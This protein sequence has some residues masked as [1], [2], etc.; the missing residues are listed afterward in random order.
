MSSVRWPQPRRQRPLF[1]GELYEEAGQWGWQ[2]DGATGRFVGGKPMKA[3]KMQKPMKNCDEE[4]RTPRE[5]FRLQKQMSHS[6]A[7]RKAIVGARLLAVHKD[8]GGYQE[9]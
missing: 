9:E 5:S 2:V 3:T 6:M 1:V 4:T 7:R 8:L